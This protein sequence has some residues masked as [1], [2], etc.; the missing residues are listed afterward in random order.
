[1]SD[2]AITFLHT[3]LAQQQAELQAVRAEIAACG[4]SAVPLTHETGLTA[5]L[6]RTAEALRAYGVT[7]QIDSGGAGVAGRDIDK[8][9]GTFVAGST[10]QGDVVGQKI[11]QAPVPEPMKALHQLRAPVADFVGQE[12]AVN[13]LVPALRADRGGRAAAISG[14][15]GMGGIGKTELA[16]V[17]ATQ[18]Q[19][20]YPDAQILLELRGASDTLLSSAQVLQQVIRAFRPEEKLPEDV[21]VL[22]A[23]Y[24]SVL[25]GQRVFI[26]A[27]DAKDIAQ[28][29][30][31]QPPIGCALPVTSRQRFLLDGMTTLDLYHAEQADDQLV[32]AHTVLRDVGFSNLIIV[33]GMPFFNP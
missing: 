20:D 4:P 27:D 1:M 21:S 19:A 3:Q 31:L 22:Q 32:R 14:G 18:L 30:P 17:V 28:V 25:T 16:L 5:A 26:L 2:A 10:I 12:E 15:R 6:E 13:T 29:R 24:R 9:Q 11:V 33:G 23:L 7:V 8:R